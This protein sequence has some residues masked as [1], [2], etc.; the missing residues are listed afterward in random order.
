MP[1]DIRGGLFRKNQSEKCHHPLPFSLLLLYLLP[2]IC[3]P[4]SFLSLP[5]P[6]HS[7]HH[8]GSC[9]QQLPDPHLLPA[10]QPHHLREEDFHLLQGQKEKNVLES[11]IPG[12]RSQAGGRILARCRGRGGGREGEGF[13]EESSPVGNR[14]M[15]GREGVRGRS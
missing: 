11:R 14:E 5:R 1:L 15:M 7:L 9:L 10:L 3:P 8:H 4:S 12:G 6:R 2:S 13:H